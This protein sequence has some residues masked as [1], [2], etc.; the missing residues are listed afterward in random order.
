MNHIST[1]EA[2]ALLGCHQR[3]VRALIA[4]G[5]IEAELRGDYEVSRRSVLKYLRDGNPDGRGWPRG[6]KRGAKK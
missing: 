6:K 1:A 5:H 2:A 3:H 4:R